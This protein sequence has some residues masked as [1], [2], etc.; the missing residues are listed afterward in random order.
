MTLSPHVI[1]PKIFNNTL[2]G[3]ELNF[4]EAKRHLRKIEMV[5][6]TILQRAQRVQIDNQKEPLFFHVMRIL[7]GIRHEI[8]NLEIIYAKKSFFIFWET[9]D[10]LKSKEDIYSLYEGLY[11][12]CKEHN[13]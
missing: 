4:F 10:E 1:Y 9:R 11:N 2:K 5:L 13:L 6:I 7:Y 8:E 3:S 12:F